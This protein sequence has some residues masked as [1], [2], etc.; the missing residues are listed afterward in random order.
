MLLAL[1]ATFAY[2][3][4]GPDSIDLSLADV[5]LGVALLAALPFVPWRAPTLRAALKVLAAYLLV[6]AIPVLA[7]PSARAFAEWGHRAFLVGGS[8]VVGATIA[9]T[10]RT[11]RALR[12]FLATAAVVA[13]AAIIDAL[14]PSRIPKTGLPDAGVPVRDPQ[15]RRGIPARVR[16]H[17]G[18]RRAATRSSSRRASARSFLPLVFAGMVACQSRGSAVTLVVVLGVWAVRERRIRDLV[19][20][21]RRPDRS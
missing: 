3:R 11:Q 6:L 20:G 19:A 7:E 2:Y 5:T 21:R 16:A 18:D 15:E 12:W 4:V 9:A 14:G 17:P 1:P 8:I 10:G 13:V